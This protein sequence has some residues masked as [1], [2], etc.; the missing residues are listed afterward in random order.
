MQKFAVI[1]LG[2]FGSTLAR[3]LSEKGAEVI[4]IDTDMDKVEE[5]QTEVTLA[6]QLNSQDPKALKLQGVDRV[7]I[8]IVCIGE[9]FES[10][11]LT[12]VILKQLGVKKVI[13][14]YMNPV[15]KRIL[16]MT[17]ADQV[18]APEE[19]SGLK[20]AN[21]LINPSFNEI[22]AL[23]EDLQVVEMPVPLPFV[24][25][26]LRDVKL[27]EKYSLNLIAIKTP[28]AGSGEEEE[29]DEQQIEG[30]PRPD[31]LFRKGDILIIFGKEK[32]LTRLT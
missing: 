6:V 28:L 7:D 8:A 23:S 15:Q 12:T 14:R 10:N 32:N 4:A 1:G 16:K 30:I 25:K 5:I 11:V 29:G 27:R 20:L 24:G 17:G 3:R 22:L 26:T 13:T 19:E 31:R 9:D 2:S 21:S 18:V